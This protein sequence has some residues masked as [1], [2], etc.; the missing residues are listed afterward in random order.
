MQKIF[1]PGAIAL[2][3]MLTVSGC[4]KSTDKE[5]QPDLPTQGAVRPKG[6]P[7]GEIVRKT[8][9]PEGGT[10]AIEGG[11]LTLVVPPGAV[12][13]ATDFSMQPVTKTLPNSPG[14]SYRLLPEGVTF[15][16]PVTL[17][18]RYT[19]ED[20]E[21][22]DPQALF[23]AFQA[24]DGI[25]RYDPLTAIDETART[26]TVQTTHFSDWGIFAE[27]FLSCP[28][29]VQPGK[30]IQVL[31]HSPAIVVPTRGKENDPLQ[32]ADINPLKDPDNIRN[33]ALAGEGV[34]KPAA[35]KVDAEYTA[36]ARTP[37]RNPVRISVEVWN[38]VPPG[39]PR[40]RAGGKGRAIIWED[41]YIGEELYFKGKLDNTD[42]ELTSELAHF[43]RA[44]DL[45]IVQGVL[46]NGQ[47]VTLTGYISGKIER[48]Y[49]F[50]LNSIPGTAAAIFLEGPGVAFYHLWRPCEALPVV[51]PGSLKIT[52]HLVAGA[53]EY[54]EGEFSCTV[55]R[56]MG[57]CPYKNALTH[58]L[59]GKFKVRRSG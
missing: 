21:G 34:L 38:F 8:I 22:T 45:L 51:S 7:D 14:K 59:S 30:S 54:L 23:L 25:W 6:V 43:T 52:K 11:R 32:I 47:S 50:N 53:Y 44:D 33:W 48:T 41:V 27:F 4:K 3:L 20:L 10:L 31:L 36:P 1:N 17:T 5:P 35:K 39:E 9:G 2:L 29:T 24:E 49:G 18:L 37:Q 57:G 19:G 26:L 55:Y 16:K 58:T 12:A 56:E 46:P 28:R 15:T 13:A 40:R 42:F